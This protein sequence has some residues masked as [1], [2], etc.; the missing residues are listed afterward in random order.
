M[1]T[2]YTIATA[3]SYQD[4][5]GSPFE[6]NQR[7]GAKTLNLK[8]SAQFIVAY[9]NS[10]AKKWRDNAKAIGI[11]VKASGKDV[12]RP[13]FDADYR[14]TMAHSELFP[15]LEGASGALNLFEK[16]RPYSR[17]VV[18]YDA[19]AFRTYVENVIQALPSKAPELVTKAEIDS[20]FNVESVLESVIAKS[21]K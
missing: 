11:E 1:F 14:A 8:A 5:F 13:L 20:L 9:L 15:A 2:S 19:D 12:I 6:V 10:V 3:E 7:Q 21:A 16:M 4:A 17:K 18:F